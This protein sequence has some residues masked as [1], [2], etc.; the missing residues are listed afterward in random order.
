[1][2]KRQQLYHRLQWLR[3]EGDRLNAENKMLQKRLTE[4]KRQQKEVLHVANEAMLRAEERKRQL[5][6]AEAKIGER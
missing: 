6:E 4:L 5:E 2:Q 1:M 3:S